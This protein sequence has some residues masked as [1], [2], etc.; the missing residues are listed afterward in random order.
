MKG[1]MGRI[2]PAYMHGMSLRDYF[3]A[4][5]VQGMISDGATHRIAVV[6]AGN[7][8]GTLAGH[9]YEIADAMIEERDK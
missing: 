5:A 1:D 9:A 8:A 6:S 3:A 4:A 7:I 2:E